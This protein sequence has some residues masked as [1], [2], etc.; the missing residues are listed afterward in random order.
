MR[1]LAPHTRLRRSDALGTWT[2]T[3][4]LGGREVRQVYHHGAD[5]ARCEAEFPAVLESWVADCIAVG[6]L[7]ELLALCASVSA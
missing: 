5:R 3:L 2:A 1:L 6:M 4:V 7:P